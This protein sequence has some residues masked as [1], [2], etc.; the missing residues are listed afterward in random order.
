M[1]LFAK[2]RNFKTEVFWYHG[3]TGGGKSR[4]ANEENPGAYW[5][6]PTNKW[7]CGYQQEDCVIIDD[8]RRDFCTFADLLRLF[9]FNPL[10]IETKHGTTEF[11]SRKIVITSPRDPRNTWAGRTTEE[12]NQLLRRIEHIELIGE[13]LPPL[14]EEEPSQFVSTFN[15]F[16]F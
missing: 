13:E 11:C 1:L 10:K 3:A 8:Y 16:R 6:N 4:R 12:L 5:K 2:K 7:W 9:D 15:R 14:E